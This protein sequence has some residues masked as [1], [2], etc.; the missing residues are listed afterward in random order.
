MARYELLLSLDDLEDDNNPEVLIT[1]CTQV[2]DESATSDQ[3]REVVKYKLH[4]STYATSSKRDGVYD[5]VR[6]PVDADADGDYGDEQD[7]KVLLALA[8]AF[9]QL[10]LEKN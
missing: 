7:K 6:V 10:N 5:D 3:E 1:F 9:V 2:V 4:D 8:N